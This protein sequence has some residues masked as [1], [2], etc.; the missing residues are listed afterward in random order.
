MDKLDPNS[1]GSH[2]HP[3]ADRELQEEDAHIQVVEGQED[4]EQ[5]E[6]APAGSRHVVEEVHIE[7]DIVGVD[8]EH[9]L[10]LLDTEGLVH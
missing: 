3:E 10:G 8:R 5:R 2:L 1:M 6:E 4:T 7:V 9:R